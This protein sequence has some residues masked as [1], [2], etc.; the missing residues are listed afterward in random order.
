MWDRYVQKGIAVAPLSPELPSLLGPRDQ[1]TGPDWSK[2]MESGLKKPAEKSWLFCGLPVISWNMG[3]F[4]KH[5]KLGQIC[6]V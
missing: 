4:C 3:L 2:G 6:G 1:R 5:S